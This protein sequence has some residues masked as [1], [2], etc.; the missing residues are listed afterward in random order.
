MWKLCAKF[1]ALVEFNH[2]VIRIARE[3][4]LLEFK[5]EI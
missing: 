1:A 2:I 3:V 4:P 5:L